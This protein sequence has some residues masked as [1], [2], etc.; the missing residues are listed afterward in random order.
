[1]MRYNVFK[2]TENDAGDVSGDDDVVIDMRGTNSKT[3][4]TRRLGRNVFGEVNGLK[5]TVERDSRTLTTNLTLT[6]FLRDKLR[7]LDTEGSE[8]TKAR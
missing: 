2:L 5:A 8:R 6:V 4:I 3:C 1:M 7:R